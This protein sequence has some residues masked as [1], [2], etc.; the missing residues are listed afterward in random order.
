MKDLIIEATNRTPSVSFKVNGK[1][2]IGDSSIPED[3]LIFYKA[4]FV[5][6]DAYCA[7]PKATTILDLKLKFFNTSTSKCLF[8]IFQKLDT[9]KDKGNDV[10]I[11]WYYRLDDTDM[12]ESGLDFQQLLKVPFKIHKL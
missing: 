4:L 2:F 3:V 12:Y 10:V 6:M 1:L 7:E 8:T 5:W 11:N 9:I